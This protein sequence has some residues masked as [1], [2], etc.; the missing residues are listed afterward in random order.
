M[1]RILVID[2]QE[3][4]LELLRGVFEGAGHHVDTL[5]DAGKAHGLLDDGDYDVVFTDLRLG[6][7][8]DGLEMLELV[9]QTCARTQVIM[10]RRPMVSE[11]AA[12]MGA[13]KM[14]AT[15]MKA[16]HRP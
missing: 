6:Y 13:Q 2:D 9:K 15:A 5:A 1:V 16:R 7:P 10:C 8:F 12:A 4:S 14:S 11:S 3:S